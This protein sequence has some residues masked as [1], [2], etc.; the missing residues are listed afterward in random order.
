ML[1]PLCLVFFSSLLLSV[2]IVCYVDVTLVLSEIVCCDCQCDPCGF[3]RYV[4]FP[5]VM[6]KIPPPSVKIIHILCIIFRV[7]VFLCVGDDL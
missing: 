6:S 3:V 5:F 1:W 2:V 7:N 4:S